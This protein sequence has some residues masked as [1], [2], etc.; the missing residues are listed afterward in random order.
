[1]FL[2]LGGCEKSLVP[3][4]LAK[5]LCAPGWKLSLAVGAVGTIFKNICATRNVEHRPAIIM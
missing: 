2:L 3:M 5:L 4:A 1:M